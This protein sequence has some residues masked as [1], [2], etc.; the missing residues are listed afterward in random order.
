MTGTNSVEKRKKSRG[1]AGNCPIAPGPKGT[2]VH[3]YSH[4][5]RHVLPNLGRAIPSHVLL[6]IQYVR[7]AC[8]HNCQSRGDVM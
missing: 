2:S 3:V 8:R 6:L 4:V 7:L 5:Q 1:T